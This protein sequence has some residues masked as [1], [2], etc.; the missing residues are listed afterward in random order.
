[1]RVSYEYEARCFACGDHSPS[2]PSPVVSRCDMWLTVCN[3]RYH[4][5]ILIIQG[6]RL[7]VRGGLFANMFARVLLFAMHICSQLNKH[8]HITKHRK[9]LLCNIR[10]VTVLRVLS[11]LRVF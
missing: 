9:Q 5:I 10:L 2:A 4:F 1:M 8:V 11:I 7:F 6:Y 3:T